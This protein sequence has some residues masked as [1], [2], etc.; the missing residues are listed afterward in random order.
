MI[1]IFEQTLTKAGVYGEIANEN[2]EDENDS[3]DEDR[4]EKA[5]GSLVHKSAK[6]VPI[7]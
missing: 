7:T 4:N 3:S 1:Q 2:A 6:V 5:T